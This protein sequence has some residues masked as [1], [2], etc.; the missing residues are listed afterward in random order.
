MRLDQAIYVRLRCIALPLDQSL[1]HANQQLE[2]LLKL[3]LQYLQHTIFRNIHTACL[4][5]PLEQVSRTLGVVL[6]EPH[7]PAQIS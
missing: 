4:L 7:V 3:M 1:S 5:K 2:L 6:L